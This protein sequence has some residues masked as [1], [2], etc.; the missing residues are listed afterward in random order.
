MHQSIKVLE[1]E[2]TFVGSLINWLR[3]YKSKMFV[4]KEEICAFAST[5]KLE[6]TLPSS[7]N[8]LFS[9]SIL[10]TTFSDS[11]KRSG[12]ELGGRYQLPTRNVVL[13]GLIISTNIHSNSSLFKS[14]RIR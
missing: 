1:T 5:N 10:A 11:P 2:V 8:S 3:P 4:R 7:Y 9:A 12:G 6:L 14:S 13:R